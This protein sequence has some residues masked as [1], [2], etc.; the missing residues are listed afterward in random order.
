MERIYG[1][2]R[3]EEIVGKA[4]AASGL[5]SRAVIRHESR[6]GL[7]RAESLRPSRV[8]RS[9]WRCEQH[10]PVA[11]VQAAFVAMTAR[12]RNPDAASAFP[13]IS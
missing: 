12:E 8:I 4:L 13:T 11:P 1:F 6:P 5:R 10:F 7:A 2:G 3:S 9:R